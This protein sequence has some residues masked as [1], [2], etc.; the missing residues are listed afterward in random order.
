MNQDTDLHPP[1]AFEFLKSAV[2]DLERHRDK[3]E[4]TLART[5]GTHTFDDL[6]IMVMQGRVRLWS[7]ENS[8]IVTELV[9][10]PQEK[11]MH[12][13]LAGGDLDEIK[14][15]QGVVLEVA[16]LEGCSKMTLS[17]RRGWIKAIADIGWKEAHTSMYYQIEV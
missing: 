12:V 13:W 5:Y 3:I 8:F 10:Y 14:A 9:V 7:L 6:C 16:K 15:M 11:H 1:T 4:D 17:G 2:A